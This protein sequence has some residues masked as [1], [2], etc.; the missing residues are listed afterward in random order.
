MV[1]HTNNNS[2]ENCHKYPNDMI[3][4]Q[5]HLNHFSGTLTRFQQA[6]RCNYLVN[7]SHRK[8]VHRKEF[9]IFQ[10][11]FHYKMASILSV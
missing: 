11:K 7:Q 3:Y 6:K 4:F 10:L 5:R 8:D 1:N 2:F 9:K